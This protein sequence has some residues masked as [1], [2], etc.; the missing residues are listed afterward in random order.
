LSSR[1]PETIDRLLRNDVPDEKLLPPCSLDVTKLASLASAFKDANV[2]I[3]LV[4][5]MHGSQKA[6]EDIQWRG[7]ENVATAAKDVGAKLIHISAIGADAHS[8][9]PYARTKGLAENSV[10]RICPDA[11]ILRPS[12]IFGPQDNFFNVHMQSQ[13]SSNVLMYSWFA[14]IFEAIKVLAFLA[15]LRRRNIPFPTSVCR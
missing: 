3:S 5:V 1:Q 2:I 6:F 11:T 9:I 7:A 14:E 4:G 8:S 10:L 13:S 12:I 15:R